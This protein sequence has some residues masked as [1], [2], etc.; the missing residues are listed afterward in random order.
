MMYIERQFLYYTECQ[1]AT[2]E[3][4]QMRKSSSQ[5]DIRRQAD[6][7]NGMLQQCLS[8]MKDRPTELYELATMPRLRAALAKLG[9]A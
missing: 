4:L 6:I 2:L 1:F 5:S 8:I 7:C 3:T 9:A